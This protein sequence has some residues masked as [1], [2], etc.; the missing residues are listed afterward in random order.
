MWCVLVEIPQSQEPILYSNRD[1]TPYMQY[2]RKNY[3][4]LDISM[5]VP[6]DD[7]I[8]ISHSI[9]DKCTDI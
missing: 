4:N 2:Q 9:I 8:K 5:L 1:L 7:I 3:D 6:Y